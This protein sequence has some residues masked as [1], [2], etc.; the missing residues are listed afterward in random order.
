MV[1]GDRAVFDYCRTLFD[2]IGNRVIYCGGQGA[3]AV[4]K[5]ANNLI[6]LGSYLLVS[7]A[8]TIGIKAG[9][10]TET[11][12]EAIS[13]SSGNTQAM[14]EFPDGLLE[15]K[16]VPGFPLDLGVKD[17]GL[18]TQMARQLEVP[19]ELANIVEKR[20]LEAKERGWGQ[21]SAVAVVRLQ[22]EKAKVEIR[23]R[24]EQ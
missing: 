2:L 6:N 1:G 21:L 14:Q 15:G 17:V 5:I 7:E 19:T 8:L 12:F 9:V 22:E 23:V 24:Q 16:F 10:K 13:H 11:L 20:F 18:A 4:C 3:G